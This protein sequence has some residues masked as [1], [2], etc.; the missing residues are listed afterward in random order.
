MALNDRVYEV[1]G[2]NRRLQ[3]FIEEFLEHGAR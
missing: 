2:I 3:A 1:F